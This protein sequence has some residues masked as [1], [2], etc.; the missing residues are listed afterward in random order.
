MTPM[1][2]RRPASGESERGRRGLT[3]ALR[4]GLI[5]SVVLALVFLA[6]L[7]SASGNT[8]L[9]ERHYPALISGAI[10]VAVAL[11]VLVLEL[12]RRLW[13]RYRAGQF[14]TRLLL[15]MA[16]AFVAMAVI[17]VALVFF[18]A[19]QFL[20]RSVE[21]WFDVPVERALESGLDLGRATLESRLADLVQRARGIAG[22]LADDEPA[23]WGGTLN[24]L[25]EQA[26]LED[27]LIVAGNG[28]IVLA[29]GT[30][31]AQ[32]VPDPPPPAA[33][34]QARVA[35]S[36]GAIEPV[37]GRDGASAGFRLRVIVPV[38]GEA[39]RLDDSRF[40]QVVQPVPRL[41]AE[42]AE[43]VQRG[44]R[45]YQELSLSRAGLKRIFRLTLTLTFLLTLF[46]AVAGA[47]LLAGWL[48]GPLSELASATK[49]VAEG[50]FRQV[51]DYAG[52]DEL[53]VLT[54]SFNAM[55]RQL[56][57][58]RTQV[59]RNQRELER[60][61]AR[62]Q[63]ILAH[64]TAGVLVV[65]VDF[66]LTLANAGASRILGVPLEDW[67]DRPLVEVPRVGALAE[68]IR[69]AFDEQIAAGRESWQRQFVLA[70]ASQ[71][72]AG[73]AAAGEPPAPARTPPPGREAGA[74]EGQ[75]LLARGSI[76]PERRVGY[77][78]VFDDITDLLSAQRAIAWAEV[79]R[80]LAHEIKNPLTPIQLAAERT[81]LKLREKLPPAEAELLDRNTA[82]IVNQ[83]AALNLLVDEFRDYARLPA[84]VLA[85]LDLGA[86]V[87]E[88]LHLYDGHLALDA[89]GRPVRAVIRQRLA[90]GLPPVLGD[91]G[92]LRQ[93]VHNLVK[94]ALEATERS[95]EPA[96]DVTTEA[97][98]ASGVALVVRDN[99]GGFPPESLARAFEPYVTSKPRGSGLGLAI[100]RKIADEH[101]ARVEAGN[102]RDAADLPVRGAEVRL[103][104]TKLAK[105]DENRSLRDAASPDGPVAA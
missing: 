88:V 86:L 97:A 49:S 74:P 44:Y 46:A 81:A 102:W 35:R 95:A 68:A 45:D 75:T 60:A 32:L 79:A 63:S 41:L 13:L 90:A 85:P 59:E 48:T 82:T 10:A 94:N 9:F 76:L 64:L 27:A 78:L 29:S 19:A 21:S 54:Q 38:G 56:Q 103:V 25:R 83:V 66:R 14:G 72:R 69:A 51:K 3:R 89:A 52:R 17:P 55:T 98:G 57:E 58:A 40:L 42:N 80:R 37:D 18:V 33:L 101:G 20:E 71:E 47:F 99:G 96:I 31:F 11:F 6:L 7:A 15:R 53:G 16:G 92:Q 91:P 1:P 2:G 73:S 24:R 4:F 23:L 34:R 26:D 62:L 104:F 43:A 28:R 105:S 8:R 5:V 12:I 93:V 30:G 100:V 65:D 22:E 67:L 36:F 61:N 70:V 39:Q 84:A 87:A 77:V 50:Q